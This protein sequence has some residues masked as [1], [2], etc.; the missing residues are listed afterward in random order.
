MCYDYAI[1]QQQITWQKYFGSAVSGCR[2]LSIVQLNDSGFAV[3][4]W[5][6]GLKI[7][8]TD[9]FGSVLW[10][11]NCI[12]GLIGSKIIKTI[13]GGFAIISSGPGAYP[14]LIKTNSLGDTLWT[15]FP[16]NHI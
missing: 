7:I 16:K 2:G 14:L 10:T 1:A 4:G 15:H 9:K 5:S 12:G 6:P 3:L 8:R 13:D 11:K